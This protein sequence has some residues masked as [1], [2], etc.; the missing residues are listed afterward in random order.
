MDYTRPFSSHVLQSIISESCVCWLGS[1]RFLWHWSSLGLTRLIGV[2]IPVV[3]EFWVFRLQFSFSNLWSRI[4]GKLGSLEYGFVFTHGRPLGGAWLIL[5]VSLLAGCILICFPVWVRL[6]C[7]RMVHAPLLGEV[8]LVE[9]HIGYHAIL[10]QIIWRLL[11]GLVFLELLR[12][13]FLLPEWNYLWPQLIS[14]LD[15]PSHGEGYLNI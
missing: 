7:F 3:I 6:L 2:D 5:Q 11:F 12:L 1:L 15:T 9:F 4:F 13:S 10:I 8:K 14:Y